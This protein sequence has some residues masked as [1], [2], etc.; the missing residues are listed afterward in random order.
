MIFKSIVF[1]STVFFAQVLCQHENMAVTPDVSAL[2]NNMNKCKFQT[3]MCCYTKKTQQK[4][5]GRPADNTDVCIAQ[6]V[7]T[8]GNQEGATHCHGFTWAR[9][10]SNMSD[11]NKRKLLN[12]VNNVDH[13]GKRG[14]YDSVGEYNKC[15]CVEN[16]PVVSRSDCSQLNGN[17]TP[18]ACDPRLADG[19]KRGNGNNLADKYRSLEGNATLFDIN[20]VGNCN[21]SPK[22]PPALPDRNATS[23]AVDGTGNLGSDG[24]RTPVSAAPSPVSTDSPVVGD[25][26]VTD[27]AGAAPVAAPPS[28]AVG[29]SPT[30]NADK[31]ACDDAKNPPVNN[32]PLPTAPNGALDFKGNSANDGAKKDSK[33]KEPR[34]PDAKDSAQYQVPNEAQ[35]PK[36]ATGVA[37][38]QDVKNNTA[39]SNAQKGL[40]VRPLGENVNSVAPS[41]TSG[42]SPTVPTPAKETALNPKLP[43][44]SNNLPNAVGQKKDCPKSVQDGKK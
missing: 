28:N 38:K 44:V 10:D 14:Y 20:L 42:P 32:P 18:K 15:D 9:R 29:S 5:G 37:G 30:S 33:Q 34:K 1:A 24:V 26:P 27:L 21:K 8:N 2:M 16:M 19:S 36:N 3:V 13:F 23:A 4:G 11:E 17:R 25:I 6:G 41:S 39:V 12:Y 7:L 22:N 40:D 35:G 31:K 43:V